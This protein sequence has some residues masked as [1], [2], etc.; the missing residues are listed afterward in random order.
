VVSANGT[1]PDH[2]IP[3]NIT[4]ILKLDPEPNTVA[5]WACRGFMGLERVICAGGQQL[6][7]W[8]L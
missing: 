5:L 6:E 8:G 4:T 3:P 1:S 7:G 2:P